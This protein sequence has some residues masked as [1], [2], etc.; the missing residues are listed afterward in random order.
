MENEVEKGEQLRGGGT[1]LRRASEP[2]FVIHHSSF[3]I[4]L[5]SFTFH[6]SSFILP[7]RFYTSTST[8]TSTLHFS[9]PHSMGACLSCLGFGPRQSDAEV[10]KLTT[11]SSLT[12]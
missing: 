1:F 4:H 12:Y 5:P 10:G 9:I 11:I 2:S 8:S 6:Q 7:T 3:I